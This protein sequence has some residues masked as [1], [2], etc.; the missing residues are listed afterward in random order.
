MAISWQ[1]HGLDASHFAHLFDLEDAALAAHGAVRRTAPSTPGF[2]CRISL[3]DAP[4]GEDLLLLHFEHH[5]A[6]SPYRAAGPIY[7]RCHATRRVLPPG[8]VPPYVTSR[9]ISVRAYDAAG[10]MVDGAVCEG[11]AVAP[12]LDR[13]FADESV[14]YVHLHNAKRGCYSCKVVRAAV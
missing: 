13:V 6:D 9:L 10:F 2:P 4:A 12:E 3:E 1:L 8:E 7:V 14:A 5:P 11:T